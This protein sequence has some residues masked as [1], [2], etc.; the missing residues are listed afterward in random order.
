MTQ[1]AD[2]RRSVRDR[3]LLALA[4]VCL[5]AGTLWASPDDDQ[6][7]PAKPPSPPARKVTRQ[8]GRPHSFEIFAGG[9]LL[10]SQTLGTSAATMVAN[11]TSSTPYTY[12]T[13]SGTRAAAPA[14]R[15]GLG[16]N[17]TRTLTV[18]GRMLINRGDLQTT[19]SGDVESAT[20]PQIT[21]RLTQ[22]DFDGSVLA[23]LHQIAFASGAGVPYVAAGIGYLRQMHEGNLAINSGAVFN[24][25][26]GVRYILSQRRASALTGIGLRADLR[27]YVPRSGYSFDG[28]QHMFAAFGGGVLFMF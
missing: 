7:P 23:H 6:R 5:A 17:V 4:V 28:S 21:S 16:Y 10:L 22:Y 3:A 20:A 26:G 13:A 19:I 9:D 2:P 18:E 1:L 27:L 25:G 12:F 15:L 8:P 14:L 11:T 24:F